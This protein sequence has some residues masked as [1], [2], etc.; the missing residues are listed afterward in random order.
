MLH[1]CAS[2]FTLYTN[3]CKSTYH[4]NSVIKFSND[5]II[6]SL[7]TKG[8]FPSVYHNAVIDNPAVIN[9]RQTEQVSPLKYLG[10]NIDNNF[11]WSEHVE[12]LCAKPAQRLHFLR[13]LRMV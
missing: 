9:E 10:I 11:I 2:L 13:R 4:K 1:R 6:V 8:D 7:L 5:T 12:H 3:D